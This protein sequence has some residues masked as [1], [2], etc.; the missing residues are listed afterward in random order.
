MY[1]LVNEHEIIPYNGEILKRYVGNRLVKAIANP[2]CEM[3]KEFGYMELVTSEK[4]VCDEA[5]QYVETK[6]KEVDGKIVQEYEV[7]GLPSEDNNE[8]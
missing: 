3:L 2:T 7:I 8:S 6:Y 5:T 1:L 4:P